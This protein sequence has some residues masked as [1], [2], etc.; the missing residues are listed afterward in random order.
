MRIGAKPLRLGSVRESLEHGL[1]MA[2]EDRQHEGLAL[3]MSVQ[4]NVTLAVLPQMTRAGLL[5]RRRE[6]DLTLRTMR[7]LAVKAESPADPVESLSGGNQQKV[8]L[9]KWLATSPKVLILDEPTRGI[10]VAA[11]AEVHRLVRDLAAK[12]VAILLISSEMPEVL[13]LA[14]RTLVMREGEVA[15]ELSRA[16][17]T[18]EKLLDLALPQG[19]KPKRAERK[20]SLL[21]QL[22]RKR[23]YGVGFLLALTILVVSLVN[24]VFLSPGNVRDMLVRVAPAAIA[25]CGMTLVL[26]TREIDISIGSLMG[27]SAAVLG[28]VA[29]PGRMGAPVWLGVTLALGL[30]AAVGLF[31][32]V[33]VAYGK[34]P[35]I[36]VTLGM[37]TLLRGVTEV[38]MGGNW[39]TELPPGL[40]VFGTG[41]WLG[42]PICVWTALACML[43]TAWL[44]ARTP[45]GRRIVAVGSSP[46]S[47]A[48][49]GVSP[50][51]VRLFVF[52]FTGLL[53]ALATLVSVPQLSTIESGIGLGFELLVITCVVVGGTS[54]S[55]GKGGLLGSALGVLLLGIVASVLIFLRLGDMSTYW[56]RAVQGAFILVAVLADHVARR[57]SAEEGLA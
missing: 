39:I 25:A 29:S 52:A 49:A 20:E 55:G 50:T 10:D 13:A 1:A 51:R 45:L 12:G 3:P 28:I 43:F 26:L 36:I 17:A 21:L 38:A 4:E 15:G 24:P 31:S 32:G 37:L 34:V 23:E 42:V 40:R 53:T 46:R 54:T 33:L 2:P 27:L 18:Q 41:A 22:A 35:S 11:K 9:G 44:L 6:A 7:A 57:R 47:A 56:E 5:S 14:D 16:E 48:Y 19:G 8:L 30:G